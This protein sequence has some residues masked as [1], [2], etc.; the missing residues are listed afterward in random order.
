MATVDIYTSKTYPYCIKA[1]SLLESKGVDYQE[2]RT[3]EDPKL[4]E[5]SV[6]RSGGKRTVPQVFINGYHVGGC[7]ELYAL[8]GEG[9]LDPMLEA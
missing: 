1:K 9:K 4:A 3:D 5:E 8:K 2:F 6:K 7:D